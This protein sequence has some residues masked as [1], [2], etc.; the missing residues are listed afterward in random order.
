MLFSQEDYKFIE[1]FQKFQHDDISSLL[2]ASINNKSVTTTAHDH[3]PN[4]HHQTSQ[5]LS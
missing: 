3:L 5:E 2:E 4:L 1:L